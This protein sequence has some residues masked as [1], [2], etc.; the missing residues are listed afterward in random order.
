MID[1]FIIFYTTHK[2]KKTKTV[3]AHS[4]WRLYIQNYKEIKTE[5]IE[6]RA[7]NRTVS[8]TFGGIVK[9]FQN[10]LKHLFLRFVIIIITETL[11]KLY[12]SKIIRKR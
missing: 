6:W 2:T 9:N 11:E 7:W 10:L 1:S 4:V 5:I 12:D 8:P 3:C